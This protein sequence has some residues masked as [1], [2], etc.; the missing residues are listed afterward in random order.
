MNTPP[1]IAR[2][3]A[4]ALEAC[5]MT[6]RSQARAARAA[7][8]LACASTG[9]APPEAC[10]APLRPSARPRHPNAPV[11]P[12]AQ[13]RLHFDHPLADIPALQPPRPWLA[14][15]RQ[16][17]VDADQQLMGDSATGRPLR[18]RRRRQA[19]A[20]MR[21]RQANVARRRRL[22][23]AWRAVW[24]AAAELLRLARLEASA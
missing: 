5:P 21:Q 2:H 3:L 6:T 11:R 16:R 14:A 24:Q 7:Q 15:R 4:P 12:G 20:A 1:S 8:T 23:A 13:R 22:E 19:D 9:F 18:P 10:R 17:L